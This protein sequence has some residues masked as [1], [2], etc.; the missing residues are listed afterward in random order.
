MLYSEVMSEGVSCFLLLSVTDDSTLN[1]AYCSSSVKTVESGLSLNVGSKWLVLIKH[2]KLL[3]RQIT[4][5]P[6]PIEYRQCK[7]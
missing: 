3:G 2:N 1:R 6:N 7:K 4:I 5:N